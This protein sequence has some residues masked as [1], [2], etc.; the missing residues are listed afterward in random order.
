MTTSY[1]WRYCLNSSLAKPGL[2]H[3][4]NMDERRLR[5][6]ELEIENRKSKCQNELISIPSL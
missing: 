4:S 5:V 2:R 1:V 3:Y 6:S